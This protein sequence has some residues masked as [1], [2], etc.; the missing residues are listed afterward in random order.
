MFEALVKDL[1]PAVE[2]EDT[3]N[4]KLLNMLLKLVENHKLGGGKE[5]TTKILQLHEVFGVRFGVMIVG[6]SGVGKT[7]IYRLLK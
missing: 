4:V 3:V 6:E 5:L 2:I 7:T 1:F